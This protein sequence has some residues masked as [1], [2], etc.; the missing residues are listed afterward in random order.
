M[1]VEVMSGY[2]ADGY[3]LLSTAE[4]VMTSFECN[5]LCEC[6]YWQELSNGVHA[7]SINAKTPDEA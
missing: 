6:A 4:V 2:R 5:R 3:E 7:L 1:L